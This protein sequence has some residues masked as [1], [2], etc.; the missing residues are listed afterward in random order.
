MEENN[1]VRCFVAL[2]LPR[3]VMNHVKEIQDKIQK[4][5]LF[6]GKFTEKENLHLTLKFLGEI[7]EDTVE[8]VKGRLK[9]IKLGSFEAKLRE[10]GAFSS[11]YKSYVRVIWAKLEN[12]GRLQKEVDNALE[13]LFEKEHRFM[14]HIT[15]ARIKKVKNKAELLDYVKNIKIKELKF[16]MDKFFLKK[17]ELFETGPVY[18]DLEVYCLEDSDKKK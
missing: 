4:K 6:I 2:D 1:K 8:K 15:I 16:K 7:S 14:G 5:N 18:E 17:S 10:V 12:C 11:K 13:G 3:E 9:G